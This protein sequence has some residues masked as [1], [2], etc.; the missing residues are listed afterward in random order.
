MAITIHKVL[1]VKRQHD[2]ITVGVVLDDGNSKRLVWLGGLPDNNAEARQMVLDRG[3]ELFDG[4]DPWDDTP[5][6]IESSTKDVLDTVPSLEQA[7]TFV[8]NIANLADAKVY[9]K[10][11]N[12]VLIALAERG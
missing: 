7:N 6:N 1:S 10:R 5:T 8:D 12:K 2:A 4:G 11:I 3:Q 9:L